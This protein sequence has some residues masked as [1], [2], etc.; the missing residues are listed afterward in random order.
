MSSF[1]W[2]FT[3]EGQEDKDYLNQIYKLYGFPIPN[4]LSA[5]GVNKFS[6]YLQ[7][8]NDY[9]SDMQKK[10]V[11]VVLYDKDSAGR[12]EFAS[13]DSQKKKSNLSNIKIVNK[14]ISKYD[15]TYPNDI[16]IEDFIPINIVVDAANKIIRKRSFSII[17]SE[18]KTKKS[19]PIY[20]KTPILK[21]LNEMCKLRNTDKSYQIDFET[22]EI[23]LLLCKNICNLLEYD[24]ES[25]QE[26]FDNIKIKQ[27]IKEVNA[28]AGC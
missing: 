6:G 21:F 10:P 9:C 11:V 23:K 24:K 2:R 22:L 13:L 8:M 7:F 26:I 12:S 27:F 3:V 5:G 1:C 17:K 25:Q 16:E 14:Y 15:G 4:I 19:L 18:D 28:N 20:E